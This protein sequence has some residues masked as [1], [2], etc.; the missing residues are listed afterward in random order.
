[1]PYQF[2]RLTKVEMWKDGGRSSGFKVTYTLQDD[3]SFTGW[4]TELTHMF[5]NEDHVSHYDSVELTQDLEKLIICADVNSAAT[6]EADFEGFTFYQYDE[7]ELNLRPSCSVNDEVEIDL[8]GKRLI[9]FRV[10][11]TDRVRDYRNIRTI[12]P[13]IDTPDCADS[14]IFSDNFDD[15]TATI[16]GSDVS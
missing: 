16:P 1:M 2:Y 6:N 7:T 11:V 5:G 12:C 8:T 15:M 10:V 9:G 14:Q 3:V 4:P 13:I